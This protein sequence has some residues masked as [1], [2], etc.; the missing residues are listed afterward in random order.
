[1]RHREWEKD[2]HWTLRWKR[3]ALTDHG[4]ASPAV[5]TGNKET[6]HKEKSW[7]GTVFLIGRKAMTLELQE[8]TIKLAH[9]VKRVT[10]PQTLSVH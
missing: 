1:M 2:R 3:P 6:G 10:G 9:S 8:E 5:R 4:A 7:L